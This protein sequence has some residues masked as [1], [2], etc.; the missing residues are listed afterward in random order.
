MR[1]KGFNFRLFHIPWMS[2]AM[3]QDKPFYPGHIRFF[4]MDG[5]PLQSN[6]LPY[7]VQKFYR[8]ITHNLY[9]ILSSDCIIDF[10][11]NNFTAYYLPPLWERVRARGNR[12][13]RYEIIYLK[14]LS[15]KMFFYNAITMLFW[16]RLCRCQTIS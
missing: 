15:V 12:K 16:H 5:I 11:I 7:L 10:Q 4:S 1:Q 8:R 3:K 9:L 13:K 14:T 6:A 2:F